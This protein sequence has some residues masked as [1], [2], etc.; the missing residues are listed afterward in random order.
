MDL[1]KKRRE[2]IYFD[3][4]R[5]VFGEMPPGVACVQERPD[6]VI[7]S[8]SGKIGVEVTRY[9]RPTPPDR[10]PLQEQF[11]LQ[12]QVARRAQH[13]YEKVSVQR[14]S[15]KI[16]FHPGVHINKSDVLPSSNELASA[17]IAFRPD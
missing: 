1:E 13:E 4:F 9:F 5:D 8:A 16:V 7:K 6:F 14:M 3:L 12:H 15:V 10:R 11:S 2:L 17:L